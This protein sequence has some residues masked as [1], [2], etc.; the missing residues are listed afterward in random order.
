VKR[1]TMIITLILLANLACVTEAVISPV[2]P[3]APSP[4][5]RSMPTVTI[6]ASNGLGGGAVYVRE[7]A[8]LDAPI[9]GYVSWGETY[10]LCGA[11][12]EFYGIVVTGDCVWVVQTSPECLGACAEIEK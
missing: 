11:T 3:P 5:A 10:E 2:S 9:V 1:I 8:S 7:W 4:T 12:P 6:V